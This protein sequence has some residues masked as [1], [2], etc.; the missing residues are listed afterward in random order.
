MIALPLVIAGL[1]VLHILRHEVGSNNP[2]GIDIKDSKI[3]TVNL[4]TVL[5]SIH[6]T[7][8]KT[9]LVLLCSCSFLAW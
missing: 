2:D 7:L 8:S 6:I 3:R 4:L 5:R 1:V 9:L